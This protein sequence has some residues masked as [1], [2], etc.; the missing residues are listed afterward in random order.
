MAYCAEGNVCLALG[1]DITKVRF[2]N[3]YTVVKTGEGIF[4]KRKPVCEG[5]Q[6]DYSS[7]FQFRKGV[8]H[9]SPGPWDEGNF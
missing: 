9:K 6:A 2:T 1:G 3:A 4:V 5:C 7:P 8:R